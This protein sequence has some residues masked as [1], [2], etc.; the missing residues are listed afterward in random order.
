[1][2][3]GERVEVFG[4][5][6]DGG[7]CEVGVPDGG[8][9]WCTGRSLRQLAEAEAV[10]VL[11]PVL[12]TVTV[13]TG[14]KGKIA[15]VSQRDDPDPQSCSK[16]RGC[17]YEIYVMNPDGSALT[18]LTN[19]PANDRFP[20]WSP[21]GRRIAFSR[22]KDIYV[23]NADGNNQTRLT[24]ATSLVM[25]LDWSSDGQRIIF[26]LSETPGKS[27]VYVM[28][29]DGSDLTRVTDGAWPAWSP[30]GKRIAFSRD[31][32]GRLSVMSVDD[33]GLTHLSNKGFWPA[34]SPDGE[35]IAFTS[36]RDGN[37][38]IYVMNA[39]GSALTRLTVHPGDDAFP[40]WSP[41]RQRIAFAS[42]GG[43]DWH[44]YLMN[45]DGSGLTLLTSGSEPDWSP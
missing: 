44:I 23:M 17:N 35:R 45:V 22:E 37:S 13:A 15:F 2:H 9:G 36:T 8:I 21:D 32:Y 7:W 5:L 27:G 6:A 29:M 28:N 33:S 24:N 1:M 42:R 4:C 16:G 19:N 18:R 30:N 38:E 39:D 10:P 11:Q 12:P 40:T 43:S 31:P 34:W 3:L 41:D 14:A 20:T 26:S 25:G